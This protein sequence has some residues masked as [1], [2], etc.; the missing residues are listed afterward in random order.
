[1][2]P[3][4]MDAETPVPAACQAACAALVTV[5]CPIGSAMGCA[6]FLNRDLASGVVGGNG[7]APVTCATVAAVRTLVQAQAL[8]FTCAQVGH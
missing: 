4:Y 6:A 3:E 2:P 1:M 8:G 5:G 7:A